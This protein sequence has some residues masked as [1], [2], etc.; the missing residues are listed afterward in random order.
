[1]KNENKARNEMSQENSV[2]FVGTVKY[3][4]LCTSENRHA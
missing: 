1:M 4:G 2:F 3:D